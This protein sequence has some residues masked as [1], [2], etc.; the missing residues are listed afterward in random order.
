MEVRS[1]FVWR[2]VSKLRRNYSIS[3]HTKSEFSPL[4]LRLQTAMTSNPSEY[5]TKQL[6]EFSTCEISDALTKLGSPNGGYIPDI[7][8]I[9]PSGLSQRI[10]G[11]A[12]TVQIVFMSDTSAPEL[13]SHFIDTA[14]AGTVIVIDVPPSSVSSPFGMRSSS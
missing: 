1:H 10:C 3:F 6:S 9:S 2:D 12:Y 8:L 13:S 7:N 5:L 4:K 11:P 14:P